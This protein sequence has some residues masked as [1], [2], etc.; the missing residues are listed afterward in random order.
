MV[1]R[2]KKVALSCSTN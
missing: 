2:R 1:L